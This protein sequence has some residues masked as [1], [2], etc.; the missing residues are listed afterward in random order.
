M[1]PAVISIECG[2]AYPLPGEP[3]YAEGVV[4]A[5][6]ATVPSTFRERE[7]GAPVID[8]RIDIEPGRK[9]PLID[10]LNEIETTLMHPDTINVWQTHDRA[11]WQ[12]IRQAGWRYPE[13]IMYCLPT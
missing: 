7:A 4:N 2:P 1:L 3:F 11:T 8:A 6:E 10:G 5:L 9:P 13:A 12:L